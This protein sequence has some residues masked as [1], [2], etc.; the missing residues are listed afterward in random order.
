MLL[1]TAVELASA[2]VCAAGLSDT[3]VETMTAGARVSV[4][5]DLVMGGSSDMIFG[6]PNNMFVDVLLDVKLNVF[7]RETTTLEFTMPFSLHRFPCSVPLHC[8]PMAAL[9]CDS[10]LQAWMPSYHA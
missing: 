3:F 5:I 4:L 2:P 7:S 6:V 1:A 9:K 8:R 10:V